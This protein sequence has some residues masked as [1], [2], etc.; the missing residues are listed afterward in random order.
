MRQEVDLRC[1]TPA[2]LGG[3]SPAV[4][5]TFNPFHGQR[6][7][8]A[9]SRLESGRGRRKFHGSMTSHSSLTA[10]ARV[11]LTETCNV[12][13]LNDHRLFRTTIHTV[14]YLSHYL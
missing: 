7:S 3:G 12:N 5:L 10:A 11:T 4:Y 14:I 9:T 2:A 6:P 13:R 1:A 8:C